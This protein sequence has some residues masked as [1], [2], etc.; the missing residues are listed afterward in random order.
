MISVKTLFQKVAGV[1]ETQFS[2][3]IILKGFKAHA[4]KIW[5]S[6]KMILRTCYEKFE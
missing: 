4:P 5:Q 1:R 3:L 2:E 6:L